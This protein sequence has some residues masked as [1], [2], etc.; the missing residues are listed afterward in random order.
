MATEFVQ[1][2]SALADKQVGKTVSIRG[3]VHRK[4]DQ[5]ELIF[6]II[7]DSSDIIQA[8][9]KKGSKAWKAAEK[10][11]IESSCELSGKLRKDERAPTGYEIDVSDLKIVGLAERFPIAKDVSDEFLLD[12]RH[13]SVRSQKLLQVWKIRS[14]VFTAFREFFL[15]RG[16]YETHA[17]FFTKTSESGLELF[18]VDYFGQKTRLAQTWQFYAE[19]LL[20]ALERIFTIAPSFRAE[21]SKTARH[22]TEY[23]HGEMEA[24]WMD[25]A[26]LAKVCE[27][28]ISYICQK[29]AKDCAKELKLL[30]RDPKKF[31]AIKPPFPRITYTEALKLLKKD[32]MK[33]TW[34]K[35]LRTPEEKQIT[36]HFDKPVIV[37]HYP[38]EVMAFYKPRDPKDKKVALCLDVLAPETGFEVIGGSE[39]DLDIEAM[40]KAL[41]EK[42]E[43][44]KDYDWYFDTRRYGATPH[45]G[46]GMGMDRIVQWICGLSS[47]KDAIPFPRTVERVTP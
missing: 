36:A 47:I 18:E 14:T 45:A 34:G 23:W 38:K 1:I 42:G 25:L 40:K 27:E 6:L 5:K 39:R 10:I 11:T 37:T 20:P 13:L 4:R 12:I 31:A 43:D 16:Y 3:W 22:L 35:D 46:F 21:K 8:V 24:A 7:R 9:I 41:K 44:P 2:M 26:E 28:L 17:P 33:V 30:G 19:A 32:G 29:V 15:Q